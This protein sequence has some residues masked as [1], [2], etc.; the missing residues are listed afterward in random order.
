MDDKVGLLQ[1]LTSESITRIVNA[2]VVSGTRI[3]YAGDP[4]TLDHVLSLQDAVEW[5]D[6]Y[7]EYYSITDLRLSHEGIPD[8]RIGESLSHGFS[9]RAC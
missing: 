1:S 3:G 2:L 6:L 7:P 5:A 4:Q 9:V 8:A